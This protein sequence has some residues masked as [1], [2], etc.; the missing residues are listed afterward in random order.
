[1]WMEIS[2]NY[3]GFT[4]SAEKKSC[5]FREPAA[6]HEPLDDTNAHR[7]LDYFCG[8]FFL[9]RLDLA[10]FADHHEHPDYFYRG[11]FLRHPAP[12]DCGSRHVRISGPYRGKAKSQADL[13]I[14]S[15][16]SFFQNGE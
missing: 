6:G 14:E 7:D 2:G 13:E 11:I 5:L 1:M 10:G 15:K 4:A 9:L 16:L 12:S 3:K 8:P